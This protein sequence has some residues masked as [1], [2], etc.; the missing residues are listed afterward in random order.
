MTKTLSALAAGLCVLTLSFGALAANQ[1]YKAAR[2]Q[3]DANYKS[4]KT[5]CKK[6]S[7]SPKSDCM[8]KAK[9][10]YAAAKDHAKA[11]K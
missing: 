7:G 4:A 8:A 9:A 10:D 6:L 3:A 5:E 11:L 1:P 2:Q